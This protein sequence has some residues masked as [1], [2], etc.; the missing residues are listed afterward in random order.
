[1]SMDMRCYGCLSVGEECKDGVNGCPTQ[2][3]EV[4]HGDENA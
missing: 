4:E 1:M 3:V 2:L